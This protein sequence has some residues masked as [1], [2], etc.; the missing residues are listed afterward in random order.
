MAG[1]IDPDYDISREGRE[2]VKS[3]QLAVRRVENARQELNRAE[4][5]EQNARDAL[6]KWC[7]PADAKPG[8]KFGIWCRDQNGNEVL[9]EVQTEHVE[10][11][12][13]GSI[14]HRV[15]SRVN[16]RPRK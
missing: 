6:V 15:P 16:I 11:D 8:E 7:A 3:Y 13:H 9:L 2:L 4:C 14:A 5:D 12:P 1:Q 10:G